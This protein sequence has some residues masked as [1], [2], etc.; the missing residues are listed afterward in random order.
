M[1]KI[2]INFQNI[3]LYFVNLIE[4][5]GPLSGILLIVLESFVPMLPIWLFIA[6]NIDNFGPILGFIFSWL[7]TT[8]GCILVFLFIRHII[9]T[10]LEGKL[11]KYKKG[12]EALNKINNFK[13]KITNI[14]FS[15]LVLIIAMP[16]MPSFLI[17]IAAGCSKISTK[18]FILALLTGKI[19]MIYFWTFIGTS[20]VQSILNIETFSKICILM[21]IA[22]ILSKVV[23]K[24]FNK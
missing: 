13:E 24:L 16:F 10:K 11:N 6:V 7:A 1:N 8:L 19:V 17:N 14:S 5:T 2:L 15:K 18:K 21:L 22:Y 20:L 9:L 12:Q 4:K 3:F 23:D